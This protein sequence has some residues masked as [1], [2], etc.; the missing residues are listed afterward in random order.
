VG[1]EGLVP[2]D[3]TFEHASIPATA[4]QYFLPN[5]DQSTASLPAAQQRTA[6]EKAAAT[7]LDLLSLPAMRT[8]SLFFNV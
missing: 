8:D 6:R 4:T 3:R 1:S 5:Y 7:F 2:R